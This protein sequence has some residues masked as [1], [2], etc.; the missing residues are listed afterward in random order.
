MKYFFTFLIVA[1]GILPTMAQG[2]YWQD[3]NEANIILPQ[4]SEVDITVNE[5]RTLSLDFPALKTELKRAPMEFTAEA[6]SNP[7]RLYLPLPNGEMEL[8]EV[9]ESPVMASELAAKFPSIKSFIARSTTNKL[10]SARFDISPLGFN[11][12]ISTPEGKALISPYATEQTRFYLS[13]F[14]RNLEV[15]PSLIPALSCGYDDFD[16]EEMLDI[17]QQEALSE[18]TNLS[19]RNNDV[20]PLRT[21]RLALACTGEYGTAKGGTVEAVMATFNTAANLINQ[22]FQ[23]EFSARFEL[24]PGNELLVFLN[25]STDPYANANVGAALLGQNTAAITSIIPFSEFD[26]GHVFTMACTDVGGIAGGT[27]CSA[28]KARGVTCHYTG[29]NFIVTQVMAHEIGHQFSCGHSW[30]N[31]PPSLD[32]L[33]SGNAFEPGSGSTIMSYQGSC[34]SAYWP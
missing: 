7:L 31:C 26:I 34:G 22:I 13:Y 18:Q 30:N 19:F 14:V 10:T 6:A 5:Y 4:R 20:V 2:N 16:A 32:Q 25:P 12:I 17:E 27:I 15:D 28:N 21:Y 23:L 1:I 11:A 33:S 29:L 24:I 3:F 9:V 8:M